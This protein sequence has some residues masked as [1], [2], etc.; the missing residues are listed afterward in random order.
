MEIAP[1]LQTF[2]QK[3]NLSLHQA[4]GVFQDI[5]D[6]K[7][8][9]A[10]ISA[11]VMGLAVKGETAQE[12]EALVRVMR[13]KCERIT[14]KSSDTLFQEIAPSQ[15]F[16]DTCGTGG[17]VFKTFNIST[18][19]ALLLA[20]S[21]IKVAKHG[22]R[23]ATGLCGSADVWEALGFRIDP[24]ESIIHE[25]MRSYNI[26]FLFAP[27][28]HTAMRS[29]AL[30][31]K[32]IA[33]KTIFNLAGP[34]TNPFS[35]AYQ[36]LGVYD[37]SLTEIVAR[38]LARV[39]TKRAY[40]VWSGVVGDEIGLSGPTKITEVKNSKIRTFYLKPADFGLRRLKLTQALA[41]GDPAY[42]ARIIQEVLSGSVGP[43]TDVVLANASAAYMLLGKV[44]NFRE[45]V[46]LGRFYLESGKA[47]AH[48][49]KLQE[50]FRT[51]HA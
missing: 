49:K 32:E 7:L 6:G 50:F 11:I 36:L 46:R 47:F 34:L 17:T 19:V 42:N 8:S 10:Q 5:M 45:G 29:A 2:I 13:R 18:C 33:I 24:P 20:A 9:P 14:S 48:F 35:A 44:R 38:V 51:N 37:S 16:L 27:L 4:E 15:D 43:R 12:L 3:K 23:S 41:G 30:V 22:N 25:C 21:G 26:S 28:Y 39:G 1:I 31:R 40:V